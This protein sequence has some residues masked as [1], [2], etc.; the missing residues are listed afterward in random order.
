MSKYDDII[1]LAH[2]EPSDK[3]PRMSIDN[4]AAIFAP[5]KALDG[6]TEAIDE[7]GKELDDKIILG[8]DEKNVLDEILNSLSLIIKS[9]PE[10]EIN[11]FI[12]DEFKNGGLYTIFTGSLKKIDLLT[13]ELVFTNN[14]KI[15]IEDIKSIKILRN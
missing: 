11:Y 5:F 3:H 9:K 1:N 2:H 10:V 13:K 6:Y 12:K 7:T 4:R 14:K 8:E 15:N